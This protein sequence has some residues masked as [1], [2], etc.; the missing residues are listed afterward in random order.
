MLSKRLASLLRQGPRQWV[1]AVAEQRRSLYFDP[2]LAVATRVDEALAESTDLSH[3]SEVPEAMLHVHGVAAKPISVK[4]ESGRVTALSLLEWVCAQDGVKDKLRHRYPL[5]EI[6]GEL[7]DIGQPIFSSPSPP[8]DV[9]LHYVS[10]DEEAGRDVF[11]RTTAMLA[12]EEAHLLYGDANSLTYF[13][14]CTAIDGKGVRGA[15]GGGGFWVDVKLDGSGQSE[16]G[17]EEEGGEGGSRGK[18]SSG[19]GGITKKMLKKLERA[20]VRKTYDRDPFDCILVT[21]EVAVK[22]FGVDADTLRR[23][24][25]RRQ[26]YARGDDRVRL[27]RLDAGVAVV[28]DGPIVTSPDLFRV[29]EMSE[30]GA[31]EARDGGEQQWQRVRGISFP[32]KG[33]LQNWYNSIRHVHLRDHRK[34]GAQQKLFSF[35]PLSPGSA[36]FLPHGTRLLNRVTAYLREKYREYEYEEV[37]TPLMFDTALWKVSGHYDN[38]RSNMYGVSAMEA[39]ESREE[40]LRNLHSALAKEEEEKKKEK[41]ETGSDGSSEDVDEHRRREWEVK[42]ALMPT[43]EYGLKPMNCPGHCVLFMSEQR[44]YKDLPMRIADFSPLHRNETSGSLGGLTRLRRF[45]QDDAHIFCT[46]DQMEEEVASCLKMVKDVY[47][48]LD[49][50]PEFTLSTRPDQSMGSEEDWQKAESALVDALNKETKGRYLVNDGDGAF[51][52][53]KIDI[54]VMDAVRRR[55]Q[56][57]TI[58]LD[59]QLPHAFNLKYKNNEGSD[60]QPVI[61]HRAILGSFE[62]ML[63]VTTEHFRGKWPFWMS[64]RQVAVIPMKDDHIESASELKKKLVGMDIYADILPPGDS[65]SYRVRNAQSVQ[66]NYMLVVGDREVKDGVYSV[67]RNDGVVVDGVAQVDMLDLMRDE[68]RERLVKPLI[69]PKSE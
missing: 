51:Y 61:V 47:S 27:V 24:L 10:F 33:E 21:P 13:G 28:A 32:S 3:H 38:Y 66:Y 50:V 30:T 68:M 12:A 5:V 59:F 39:L 40:E 56:C 31:V 64:P 45:T 16:D 9:D 8:A 48:T 14:A 58:Q 29:V 19:G 18:Q 63:A 42:K 55:H 60:Q 37:M 49:L 52:G 57:A 35:N 62:R 7:C 26:A 1:K 20:T 23:G 54:H 69:Q 6:N 43:G 17:A 4:A 25:Q 2:R 46:K 44:S 11:W 34:I 36:F 65:I 53:P 22:K 41:A 15:E 67:R